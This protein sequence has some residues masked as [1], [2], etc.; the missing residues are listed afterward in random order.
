[1]DESALAFLQSHVPAQML[2]RIRR[3]ANSMLGERKHVTVLFADLRGSTSMVEGMDAE[4]ALE[5]IGPAVGLMMDAVH[6]NDGLVNQTRGDG[7]MALF[8]APLSHED[9]A[10]RACFAALAIRDG[11]RTMAQRVAH[12]LVVRI[13]L[14]SGQVVIHSIGSDLAMHF[15]AAGLTTHLAA[16]MEQLAAPGTVLLTAATLELAKGFIEVNPKGHQSLRGVSA[17]VNTFE[18]T[19]VPARTRW[20]VRSARGLSVMVGREAELDVLNEARVRAEA[21][22]GQT[23]IVGGPPGFGKSRLVHDF[24]RQLPSHWIVRET[25]CSSARM[26]SSYHP[27]SSLVRAL[28]RIRPGD[29]PEAVASYLRDRLEPRNPALLPYVPA[30][31]SLLDVES[32]EPEW[33]KLDASERRQ[34]VLAAVR[35]GVMD[36]QQRAPLLLLIEDLQWADAETKLIFDDIAG[37]LG[38]AR[39]LLLA[40]ERSESS[41]SK[42]AGG[43]I[44][45]PLTP[46][47]AEEATALVDWLMGG[48]ISL[49]QVKRLVLAQAQGNPLFL[50]ELIQS[51]KDAGTLI[52]DRGR[53]RLSQSVDRLTMPETVHLVLAARIDLLDSMPKSLLQTASVIGRDVSIA[54]LSKMAGLSAQDLTPYLQT[55]ESADFLYQLGSDPELEYSFKHELTREVAYGTLLLATRRQLHAKAIEIIEQD[56]THRPEGQ[57]DR[58]AEHAYHAELWEKAV[59]Y[60]LR[61]GR[62]AVKRAAHRDAVNI[63][64]RGI[65]TLSHLPPSDAKTNSEIDF[66]LSLIVPLE[67]L[68]RHRR[69]A[70]V[71][72]EAGKFTDPCK[73]PR[74]AAAVNCQLAVG[75]WRLGEH[76]EAMAAAQSA[77]AIAE[78]ITDKPLMFAALHNIGIVEHEL[79]NFA[80]AVALHRDCLAQEPPDL[81]IKRVGWASLPSVVLRTFLADSLIELGEIAEAD[82]MGEDGGRRADDADH[83]Y[84]RAMINH[85]RG[86]IRVLQ[87]RPAEAVALLDEAWRTCLNLEMIQQFPIIAARLGEAHL[88]AGHT[89]ASMEILS[90]PE[91]LDIPLAENT[92]GWG[93][94]YLAQGA[95]LLAMGRPADGLSA[96]DRALRLG[97]LRGERPLRA[98]AMKLIGDIARVSRELGLSE[99]KVYLE[100]ALELAEACQ[101]RPLAADCRKALARG[102]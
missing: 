28:Y 87:G 29:G 37:S 38:A 54:L 71:L 2:A 44:Q 15:E 100:S 77:L 26:H 79:G 57:I 7:I 41:T 62:R 48:D 81:D 64:E 94:L 16:R 17:P 98:Y 8:G 50:E 101:M 86:R 19:G 65:K 18:L 60:L 20:Q 10:V 55:L 93:Q 85:V 21:G 6:Q 31:L 4:H 63:L 78:R 32:E 72:R 36:M 9:H 74:R 69:I 97:N 3:S 95:T 30:I 45:L 76:D 68:G 12:E 1:M 91:K 35:T 73:D 46:L 5:I 22:N 70:E 11:I 27:I 33:R 92:F 24:I 88:A 82:R 80:K 83:A 52:G 13:G 89:E 49:T 66:R 34:H 67:P 43:A 51:L 75:L 47:G 96:A 61:S 102:D 56:T 90:A 53:Y 58:L 59:P 84:S 39:I 40:T 99:P 25:V 14:N 42:V 23:V